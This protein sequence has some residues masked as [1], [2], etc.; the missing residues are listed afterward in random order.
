L[1]QAAVVC[2]IKQMLW[3][4]MRR[5]RPQARAGTA[6]NYYDNHLGHSITQE[7]FK[8]ILQLIMHQR[9]IDYRF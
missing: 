8:I 6:G 5:Q 2:K 9:E 7:L 4:I 1:Q 3:K